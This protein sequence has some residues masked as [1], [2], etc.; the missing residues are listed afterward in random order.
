MSIVQGRVDL[1]Q[2]SSLRHNVETFS[3]DGGNSIMLEITIPGYRTLRI[4]HLVLDYNGTL[5]C[6]GKLAEGVSERLAA[7]SKKLKIHVLTADT[8]GKAQAGLRG[9]PCELSILA[10]EDQAQAKLEYVQ[11]LGV[12]GVVCMG[13]GRNDR[14]MLREAPLGIT[15]VMEE[16]AAMETLNAAD[17]VCT[18]ICAALDL[19]LNPL[20][21]VATLRS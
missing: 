1:D 21:L 15:V 16:G 9:I 18:G 17:L 5:A 20:R 11:R 6:D 13:N 7:L 14:L 4:E 12:E 3:S 19:L 10:A 8:F 2:R